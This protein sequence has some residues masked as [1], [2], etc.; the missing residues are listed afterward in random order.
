MPTPTISYSYHVLYRRL[1]PSVNQDSARGNPLASTSGATSGREAS[2]FTVAAL[3]AA[4]KSVP[5]QTL[6]LRLGMPVRSPRDIA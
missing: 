6:L 1:F 5:I 3:L 2:A 4:D